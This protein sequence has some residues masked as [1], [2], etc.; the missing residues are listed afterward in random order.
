M[1]NPLS[2]LEQSIPLTSEEWEH[3]LAPLSNQS[4]VGEFLR[5]EGTYD[6]IKAARREDDTT[7]T[8]HEWD[9]ELKKADWPQ[10]RQLCVEAL[11]HRSKDLQIAVWL[12][13][14][15]L[16][17]HG[18]KGLKTGLQFLIQLSEKYWKNL[19]PPLDETDEDIDLRISPLQWLNHDKFV[20]Q[21]GVVP[22]TA[23]TV[24]DI[25]A[26]TFMDRDKA[27]LLEKL[28]QPQKEAAISEGKPTTTKFS[29]SVTLT[30]STFYVSLVADLQES[31]DSVDKLNQ[32]LDEYCAEQAPSLGKLRQKLI[33]IQH[34]VNLILVDREPVSILNSLVTEKPEQSVSLSEDPL[35]EQHVKAKAAM[36]IR[37]RSE[38][39]QRLAEIADYLSKIE[40]HSPTSY[41][42]KRAISWGEMSLTDLLHEIVN[43]ERD[44]TTIYTLLGI[45]KK[46]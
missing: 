14:A 9:T 3:L 27:L 25:P 1:A 16:H 39:Y 10:V 35:E 24:G 20:L 15:L 30:S 22:I 28:P 45:K 19:Y 11:T 34:V 2:S 38:A 12:T 8:R 13:E 40:P 26:Y 36:P 29:A 44:L 17:L 7:L 33:D 5:Y 18:Y 21:L 42:I 32:I 6:K 37:N 23:P 46:S 31:I 41:L 43:D 4:P